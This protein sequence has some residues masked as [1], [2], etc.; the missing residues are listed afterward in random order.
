[1]ARRKNRPP[2]VLRRLLWAMLALGG[3]A[4]LVFPWLVKGLGGWPGDRFT[5]FAALCFAFGLLVGW[6]NFVLFR[7]L[8]GRRLEAMARVADAL[9]RGRLDQRCGFDSGD[10]LG[11]VARGIDAAADGL[12]RMVEAV[13][14]VA[15][16]VAAV[17]ERLQEV[18]AGA[19]NGAQRQQA[20][21][22]QVVAA[23]NELAATAQ[24]VARNAG[25][26]EAATREADAQ[27]NDAKLVTVETMCTID[28]LSGSVEEVTR[29]INDLES[30]GGNIGRVLEVINGIAEQTN[31]LA[32]N[33]AIEAA[34][35]GEQGRGF[36]VVADEVRTLANRTQASTE[37]IST[38]IERLQQGTRRAVEVMSGCG[39][40]ARAGVEQAEK[41]AEALAGISGAV[42]TIHQQVSQ[43]ATAA[44]E[45]SQVTETISASITSLSEVSGQAADGARQAVAA[46][47]EL[48]RL[49][50][51]LQGLLADFR[52]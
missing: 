40:K 26:A 31:L 5:T 16:E 23:A 50:G 24:E 15:G 48:E 41:T 27:G 3:A 38:M 6:G 30:E 2:S 52:R 17:V 32:L 33:A 29:V 21:V 43:I 12:R 37:E 22:E 42:S 7:R 19:E 28:G 1:M 35:A 39:D 18:A 34:R 49:N 20:E 51:E 11:K 25:Q 13:G 8:L 44:A 14:T 4:G 10:A 36:A 9:A 45:Q 47:A 46:A